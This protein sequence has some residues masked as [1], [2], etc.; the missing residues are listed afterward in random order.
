M[1]K[2]GIIMNF[3]TDLALEMKTDLNKKTGGVSARE[4]KSGEVTINTITVENE[5]GERLLGKPI[6]KY[7]TF[8]LPAFLMTQ[9]LI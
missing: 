9:R 1:Y 7:I 6:G 4:E 3:R 2:G 5:I 8:S